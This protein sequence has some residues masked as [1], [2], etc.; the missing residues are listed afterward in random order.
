MLETTTRRRP[1][2]PACGAVC[3]SRKGGGGKARGEEG[4]P[5]IIEEPV[6]VIETGGGRAGKSGGKRSG[7]KKSVKRGASGKGAAKKRGG[8]G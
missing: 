6:R 4:Y 2:A 3:A 8:R 5:N 1:G 7:G